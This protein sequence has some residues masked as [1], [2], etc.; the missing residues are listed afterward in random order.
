MDNGVC[1]LEPINDTFTDWIEKTF[2][3]T[4]VYKIGESDIVQIAA[5]P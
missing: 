1:G 3:Y 2:Y 5:F 4:V